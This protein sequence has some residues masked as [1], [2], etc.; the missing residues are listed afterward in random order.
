MSIVKQTFATPGY[1][2]P[3][4]ANEGK[5]LA[6]PCE[7]SVLKLTAGSSAAH[8]TIYDSSTSTTNPNKIVWVLDAS[9]Q[10]DDC[11]VFTNPL[12]FKNGVYAVCDQGS[13]FNA[14]ICIARVE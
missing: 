4:T 7:V 8:V 3:A 9:T 10:D 6:G 1:W 14:E 2:K 5:Q 12:V 13:T 11:Q